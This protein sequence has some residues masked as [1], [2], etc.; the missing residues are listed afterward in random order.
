MISEVIKTNKLF[1]KIIPLLLLSLSLHPTEPDTAASE[2]QLISKVS[3]SS[4]I[5]A[6]TFDDGTDAEHI[7]EILQVLTDNEVKATFFITGSA[8][9][10]HPKLT[11]SIVANGNAIG[12][13]SFSHPQFTELS[14]AKMKKE[15]D[16][17][18][19]IIEEITGQSTKPYF[20][21]PYGDYNSSVL[22]AVGEAGYSMSVT[23]TID[24]VDW[25]GI[26]ASNIT[27]KVLS[28]ASPGSIVL[29]HASAG[30]V[31][32]PTALPDIIVGLKEMGYQFVTIPE[33]LD[34][35]PANEIQYIPDSKPSNSKLQ[36]NLSLN[37]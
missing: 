18:E 2:S 7:Q 36:V 24:T 27:E 32:T 16:K 14:S 22:Q 11:Q 1:I 26:S 19:T 8:A 29:M 37:Q 30:A 35:L 13:H 12:N 33:L 21:P 15:I 28:N 17:A 9:E 4:K 3:T 10:T 31:N 6:L 5:I 23:W 20:R 25:K 34:Y